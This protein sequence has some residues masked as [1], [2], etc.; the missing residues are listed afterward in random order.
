[1]FR[2]VTPPIIRGTYNCIYSMVLVVVSQLLTPAIVDGYRR[3][4]Y[5]STIAAPAGNI[6]GALYHKL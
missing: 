4:F 6:V 1:M 3:S 5:P 2:A